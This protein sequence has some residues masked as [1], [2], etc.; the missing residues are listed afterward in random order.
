MKL[1]AF[2]LDGTA[3][4]P[5]SSI[6]TDRLREVLGKVVDKGIHIVPSTGRMKNFLPDTI[7]ELRGVRYVVTAN[8]AG[9]YDL[10]EDRKLY[11]NL[12]ETETAICVQRILNEYPVFVEYYNGGNA[13]LQKGMREQAI[14][15]YKIPPDRMRFLQKQYTMIDEYIAFLEKEQLK[16]EKI[17]MPFVPEQH[18]DAI[19]D[20]LSSMEELLLTSSIPGNIEINN[21]YCTKGAAL[22]ALAAQLGIDRAEVMAVGDGGNDVAM[23]KYA[24]VSVAMGNAIPEAKQAAKFITA[25]NEEDGL[26]KAIEQ[27]LLS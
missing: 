10:L 22:R 11:E 3:F 4:L 13:F 24:G 27:F 14:E 19:W 8:G 23:L 7:R 16:P 20:K 21:A 9:V 26:A 25:T 17:N 6:V 1:L 12:I 15:Y 2:D 5:V 18:Y